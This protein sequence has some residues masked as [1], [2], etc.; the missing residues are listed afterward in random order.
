MNANGTISKY[1]ARLVAQGNF[2]DDSI[3][4]QTFADTS[5]AKSINILLSYAA[6]KSLEISSIDIKTAF[7]YSP[8]QE[9]LYLRHPPGLSDT[10]MPPVVQLH[11][12]IHGI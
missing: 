12:C 8:L 3:Y 2:Q 10:I 1:K 4:F 11:K 6:A 5:S 9:Q 7:L